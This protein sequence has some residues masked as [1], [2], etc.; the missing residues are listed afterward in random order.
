MRSGDSKQLTI[1]WI[2]A[3][4]VGR[5]RQFPEFGGTGVGRR[6][7][8]ARDPL[9][10]PFMSEN[11]FEK[12]VSRSRLSPGVQVVAIFSDELPSLILDYTPWTE[13]LSPRVRNMFPNAVN[14]TWNAHTWW[15]TDGK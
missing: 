7:G 13:G 2:V 8:D 3:N 1:G 14:R 12:R 4:A 11:P 10:P 5:H 9:P 6:Q 15:V